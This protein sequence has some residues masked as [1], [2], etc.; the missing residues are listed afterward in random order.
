V[1]GVG[2]TLILYT[3][4]ITELRNRDGE[5]FGEERLDAALEECSG[6]PECVV[7]TVHRAMYRFTGSMTRQDDQTLVVV[8]RTGAGA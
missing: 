1:L 8:Q 4:G 5:L 6:E 7:D 3:D 2:D